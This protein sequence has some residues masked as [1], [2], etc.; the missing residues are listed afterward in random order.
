MSNFQINGHPSPINGESARGYLLRIV[1]LN[2][3]KSVGT[4][5]RSA[6]V[7]FMHKNHFMTNKWQNVLEQF[8]SVL[9]QKTSLINS[10][11]Q[12]WSAELYAKFDM[13]ISNLFHIDCRLCPVCLSEDKYLKTD[14]DFALTTVCTEHQCY[15]VDSCPHCK[16]SIPW[17]RGQ[18]DICPNCEHRYSASVI[19]KI[20]KNH[21]LMRLNDQFSTMNRNSF[22]QLILAYS[23]MY[24]P[25][26]NILAQPAIHK[27]SVQNISELLTQALG[28]MH[29]ESY[30]NS[31][32]NWLKEQRHDDY[33][34]LSIR[35][36]LEP[37]RNFETCYRDE[38]DNHLSDITFIPLANLNSVECANYFDHIQTGEQLGVKTARLQNRRANIRC[39]DLGSQISSQRLAV[40]LGTPS[41]S[42]GHL[43]Q[44]GIIEPVNI[45]GNMR[46]LLFD[47]K[48][49]V[50]RFSR[51]PQKKGTKNHT[52]MTIESLTDEK[53]LSKFL[54][55]FSDL[56]QMT[57]KQ[58]INVYSDIVPNNG[59]FDMCV[60]K[61]ELLLILNDRLYETRQYICMQDFAHLMNT[62]VQC[63]NILLA[64]PS[65]KNSIHTNKP[66][67]ISTQC[68]YD[69]LSKYVS[70]N[71]VSY[72]CNSRV[73]KLIHTLKNKNLESAIVIRNA[74][75]VLFLYD[76][77]NLSV[78]LKELPEF[79]SEI[80]L[81]SALL[82]RL[83]LSNT[84]PHQQ[85]SYGDQ[86]ND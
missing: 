36:V 67:Q 27:M 73:D 32:I 35:A 72:F 65:F 57:L 43:I 42:M 2:G 28:L 76:R 70:L 61:N 20:K 16:N 34:F 21:P 29:S 8:S 45:I 12:H 80:L 39:I 52:L 30:R 46:H 59:L 75:K 11:S 38:L 7:S 19:T 26:D 81:E 6:G 55:K 25:E 37:F 83:L 56:M 63:V 18:L 41:H 77:H 82:S 23:R 51:I 53:L 71:R 84:A 86:H 85:K 15:L 79:N 17:T 31:Y 22:E 33:D 69:V 24:R 68:A 4:I 10:F 54:L 5:C 62:T 3:F 13:R 60:S 9:Y 14:W 74:N 58:E 50:S 1:D 49:V 66:E 47:L 48:E 78:L 44:N 64:H 40:V